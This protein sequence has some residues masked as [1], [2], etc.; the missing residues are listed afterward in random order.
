MQGLKAGDRVLTTFDNYRKYSTPEAIIVHIA[1]NLEG[2][3]KA[4]YSSRGTP[5]IMNMA[6][7]IMK[8]N[9]EIYTRK[10]DQDEAL[11]KVCALMVDQVLL[12][13]LQKITEA[14]G[15]HYN[16]TERIMELTEVNEE[17]IL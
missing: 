9:L 6:F 11:G 17:S 16:I 4:M 14:Y 1:D 3:E 8:E 13:G 12:P 7:R 5:A 2:F 10:K 15:Y